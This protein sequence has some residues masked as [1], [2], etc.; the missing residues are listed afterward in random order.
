MALPIKAPAPTPTSVPPASF[1]PESDAQAPVIAPSNTTAR[2]L[3][4]LR[5]A[6]MGVIA[7]PSPLS[8]LWRRLLT[9]PLD[10]GQ[11]SP[12]TRWQAKRSDWGE[13]PVVARHRPLQGK[14]LPTLE[15]RRS[16]R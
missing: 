14:P 10:R 13:T 5:I 6:P 8:R 4:R 3:N 2:I 15:D 1:G 16:T 11:P 12:P 9:W 7:F